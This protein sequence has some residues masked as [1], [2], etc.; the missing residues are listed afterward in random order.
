MSSLMVGET[1]INVPYYWFPYSLDLKHYFITWNV[2]NISLSIIFIN[3]KR[4]RL[5][6]FVVEEI[7]IYEQKL[8]YWP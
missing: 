4:C 5:Q 2:D 7:D 3:L 6:F 1:W 8:T